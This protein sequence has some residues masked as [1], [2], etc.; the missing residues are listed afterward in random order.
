MRRGREV[1]IRH[2]RNERDLT[3]FKE[4]YLIGDADA[5]G[6]SFACQVSNGVKREGNKL[7]LCLRSFSLLL[8]LQGRFFT[9]TVRLRKLG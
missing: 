1:N 5:Q 4:K 3:L 2:T 6:V 7:C 8:L 9:P